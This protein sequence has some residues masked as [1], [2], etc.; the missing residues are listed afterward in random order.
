MQQT[1]RLYN[2]RTVET[3]DL[4]KRDHESNTD[5][6]RIVFA[7]LMGSESSSLLFEMEYASLLYLKQGQW[8]PGEEEVMVRDA[9]V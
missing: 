1:H 5:C 2:I 6:L 4:N 7:T 8:H 3:S 9:R